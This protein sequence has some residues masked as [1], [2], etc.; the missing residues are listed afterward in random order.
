MSRARTIPEARTKH[1]I[2]VHPKVVRDTGSANNALV[3]IR[4]AWRCEEETT[5]TWKD[6]EG[7]IWWSAGQPAIAAETGLKIE[8]V[9][10]S[11]KQLVA[12]G[13]VL[14]SDFGRGRPKGYAAVD[15]ADRVVP[16]ISGTGVADYSGTVPGYSGTTDDEVPEIPGSLLLIEDEVVKDGETSHADGVDYSP[17]LRALADRIAVMVRANGHTVGVIGKGWWLPLDRLVRLDGFT[18]GQIEVIAKWATSDE[19]WAGNIRSTSKLRK[20]FS[21]LRHQRN[22]AIAKKK[23]SKD[24]R[25][26]NVIEMG[27]ELADAGQRAV[28]R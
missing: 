2:L 1:F 7:R 15:K 25:A 24:E 9:A 16:G 27:R 3:Y 28:G 18:L 12:D 8:S 21:T 22:T 4:M 10:Y 14:E 23:P 6:G 19:F 17:E 11:L 20:Q 13:W 5:E 26:L